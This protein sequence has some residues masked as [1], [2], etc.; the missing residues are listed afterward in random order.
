MTDKQNLMNTIRSLGFTMLETGLYLNAYD[1]DE[2]FEYFKSIKELF[3]NAIKEYE[4]KYGPLT[5]SSTAMYDTWTW[6]ETPWP[7]EPEADC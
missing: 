7:W 1:S 6:T 3:E 4:T 5:M 2:A